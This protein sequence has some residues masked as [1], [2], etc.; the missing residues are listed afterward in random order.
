MRRLLL[1]TVVGALLAPTT[2]LGDERF[3]RAPPPHPGVWADIFASIAVS[4]DNRT[5][6]IF[7]GAASPEESDRL[8]ERNCKV[9]RTLNGEGG[10]CRVVVRMENRSSFWSDRHA[11]DAERNDIFPCGAVATRHD[12][13]VAGAR[14]HTREEAEHGAILKCGGES[15]GCKILR[16]LCT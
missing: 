1:T 16:S 11:T 12:G 14:G 9:E 4:D 7:W 10:V 3:V 2:I 13:G 5:G 6:G 8:A 15:R